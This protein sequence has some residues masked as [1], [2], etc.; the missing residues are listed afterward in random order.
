MLHVA[1]TGI[2]Y[3]T[4]KLLFVH[5]LILILRRKLLNSVQLEDLEFL[6]VN[7]KFVSFSFIFYLLS[8][9]FH[10]ITLLLTITHFFET[11]HGSSA[12]M[13]DDDVQATCRLCMMCGVKCLY[14]CNHVNPPYHSIVTHYSNIPLNS[15]Y[16]T[17]T[18][19]SVAFSRNR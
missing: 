3:I 5:V 17:V 6:S 10:F 4:T 16:L 19:K 2:R 18:Q 14:I 15:R 1:Y 7:C 8:F 12:L 11:K 13:T 9:I